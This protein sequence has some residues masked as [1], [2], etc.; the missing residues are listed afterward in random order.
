MNNGSPDSRVFEALANPYRR[1]L[2]F[3]LFESNPQDDDAFDPLHLLKQREPIDD[4][5]A[6]RVTLHHVHLPKLV[7]RGFIEWDRESGEISKG[8][9]WDEIAPLLQLMYDSWD[10]LP[11]EWVSGIS[12]GD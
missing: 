10:E 3:A 6:T 2:L 1:Q 11:G 9:N 12:S 5:D 4:L 7:D 8:P